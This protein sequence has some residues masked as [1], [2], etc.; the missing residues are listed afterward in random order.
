MLGL[1]IN[2]IYLQVNEWLCSIRRF[3]LGTFQIT[4]TLINI[5]FEKMCL[6]IHQR[7]HILCPI[8]IET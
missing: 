8:L 3:L 1:L 7:G 6:H 4:F 2:T 5:L